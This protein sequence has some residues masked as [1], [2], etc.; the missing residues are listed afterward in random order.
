MPNS[1]T[2]PSNVRFSKR[3]TKPDVEK[4]LSPGVWSDSTSKKEEKLG[5]IGQLKAFPSGHPHVA[6]AS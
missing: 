2:L 6:E 1:R 5:Y 3:E 4:F